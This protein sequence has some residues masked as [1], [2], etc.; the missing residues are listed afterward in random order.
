MRRVGG[1]GVRSEEMKEE[2]Y[3]TE[4]G[5][6]ECLAILRERDMAVLDRLECG[7]APPE[8]GTVLTKVDGE[9]FRIEAQGP[10][11]VSNAFV[12]F[13][14]GRFIPSTNGSRFRGRI[15]MH[16]LVKAFMAIWFGFIGVFPAIF[17]LGVR[18]GES[19]GDT[20]PL[21][22]IFLAV[23]T[24]ILGIGLVK[25]GQL[26]SRDQRRSIG[27]FLDTELMAHKEE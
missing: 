22:A 6:D 10:R 14:Y 21:L 5:K 17:L 24:V 18:S 13:F 25:F 11:F 8:P 16:P 23:I 2:T 19:D 12:P 1:Q 15:Q 20:S 27:R 9:K 7:S 26:T 3:R 4:L